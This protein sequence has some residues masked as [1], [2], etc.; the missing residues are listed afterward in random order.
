MPF[1]PNADFWRIWGCAGA[2]SAVFIATFLHLPAHAES[3]RASFY[4]AESGRRT[5]SGARFNPMGFTAAHRSLPFGTLLQVCLLRCKVVVVN[6]RGPFARGRSL[7]L[8]RGAAR[9]IGL[10]SRGVATITVDRLN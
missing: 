1:S 7:D 4:G 9:A 10:E 2:L 8:S 3:M 6:D 5:A